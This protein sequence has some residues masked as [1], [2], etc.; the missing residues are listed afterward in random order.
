ME[1]L[2]ELLESNAEL[3]AKIET[4]NK[5][6]QTTAADFIALVREYGVEITEADFRPTPA[7]GEV[8]DS[9]LEAVAG[10]GK[11]VCVAGGGGTGDE[12]RDTCACVA[13]GMGFGK[14]TNSGC[15][16]DCACP[17]IGSGKSG[18]Q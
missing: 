18:L 15:G 2:Q 4:L 8:S 13:A 14:V 16:H 9:E 12:Y 3:K 6:P 5:D 11:C 10:G 17:L 1:K 7:G